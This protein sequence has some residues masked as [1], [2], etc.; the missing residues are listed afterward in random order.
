MILT[1]LLLACSTPEP[2]ETP[3][4]EA[5]EAPA[6][7]APKAEEPAAE[8]PAEEAPKAEA[9]ARV[10][11]NTASKEALAKIPEMTP[12]M[13]HE[14]EEY[15]PYVSIKQF[16]KQMGKYVDAEQITRWEP[17]V[18]VPIAHNDCDA[19]TLG[20]LPGLD[21]AGAKALV[22]G[23]PYADKDAFIAKLTETVGDDNAK[24]GAA[25]LQ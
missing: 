24:T 4:P 7:A 8:A 6:E 19:A 18:Y 22:N 23:R 3:A 25:L 13:V 11:L 21:A 17:H 12:K 16:R 15:R 14:F 10:N 1:L 2:A 9:A 20:Q 5:V